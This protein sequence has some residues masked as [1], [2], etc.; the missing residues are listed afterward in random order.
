MFRTALSNFIS[1]NTE[2]SIQSTQILFLNAEASCAKAGKAYSS[3]YLSV[4]IRYPAPNSEKEDVALLS[5]M[6][7]LLKTG[8]NVGGMQVLMLLVRKAFAL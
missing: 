7:T 3:V 2:G 8:T 5:K 4:S 6:T 1:L